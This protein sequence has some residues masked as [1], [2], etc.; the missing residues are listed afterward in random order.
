MPTVR[1]KFVV[2][3]VTMSKHWDKAKPPIKTVKLRPVVGGGSEENAKFYEATPAGQ[4]ELGTINAE[5]AAQF[6]LGAEYYVDFTK[7]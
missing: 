6:E 7:A 5:A 4:I 1:A 3:S 2:E